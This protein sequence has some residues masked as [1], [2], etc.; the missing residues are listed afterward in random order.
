M[1]K[2]AFITIIGA[3][4]AGKSTL[5][6]ALVQAKVSII[7]PKVQT[8]RFRLRGIRT[9]D[10][11]QLVFIDTPGIFTPKKR[12]DKA[13]VQAAW[14][15]VEDAD[16]ILLLVDVA[17]GVTEE[18][19]RI[20]KGLEAV[21]RPVVLVLNKI[22][23]ISKDKLFVLTQELS[24]MRDF[25][26]VFMVS[27]LKKDGVA[28]LEAY[29]VANAPESIWFYPEDQLTDIH[30][31]LFAAEITRE[32]LFRQLHQELP[33]SL[34]VETESWEY[35]KKGGIKIHQVIYVERE[36][37]KKMILGKGGA[38]IKSISERARKELS[39]LLGEEVHLF[40]FVKVREKWKENPE[41]YR[42]M[43]LEF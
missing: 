34:V 31:R 14:S 37:H 8:T 4:N 18:V 26:K 28:D 11:T 6:N 38:K 13:M 16:Q 1:T 10:E 5:L 41:L 27:A 32:K 35:S 9:I 24:A 23:K 36:A 30:E 29:L 2:A 42:M 43:G 15:G 17:G 33:Y 21:K 12:L 22:D 3:P 40:L 19:Q 20:V 7:S 39:T 25:A